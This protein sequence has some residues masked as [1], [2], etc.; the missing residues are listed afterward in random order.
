MDILNILSPEYFPRYYVNMKYQ[1]FTSTQL[2]LALVGIIIIGGLIIGNTLLKPKGAAPSDTE[3]MTQEE[4]AETMDTGIQQTVEET[5][6][7][8]SAA[9]T[10]TPKTSVPS[11]TGGTGNVQ[12]TTP[13]Q[14]IQN[15]TPETTS[16]GTTQPEAPSTPTPY[17]PGFQANARTYPAIPSEN[18]RASLP[19]CDG[20]IFSVDAVNLSAVT[21]IE[22]NGTFDAGAPASFAWVN[23][24]TKN[25]DEEYAL[26]APADIYITN[27][28]Q[29][30]NIS[31]DTQD[32]TVYFA[33][34]KDVFGYFTHVKELSTQVYKLVTD[35]SCFGKPQTGVNACSIET[36]EL[37]G[38]GSP[39][40]NVGHIEGRFGIGV[41]DLRSERGYANA[42]QY[43]V[44]TNFAV[45]PF[46]YFSGG[47][48]YFNKL[49]SATALCAQ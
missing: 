35:S 45:C 37:I 19:S 21:S 20:K 49:S 7:G 44:F 43:S 24:P 5:T 39:V 41:I 34:C 40:G 23:L 47:S 18:E 31:A 11:S 27:I 10:P 9:Q 32:S 16:P 6:S 26:T 14:P 30:N 29:E 4:V 48:G 1:G 13:V 25:S 36:L 17:N 22:A 15:Q 42:N 46:S 33:L 38:R 2:L 8:N 28:T 3:T 12:E